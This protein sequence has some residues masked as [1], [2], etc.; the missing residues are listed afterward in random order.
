MVN[1]DA[2]SERCVLRY[3][4]GGLHSAGSP[5]RTAEQYQDGSCHD[6]KPAR[7][8]AL[9][10]ATHIDSGAPANAGVDRAAIA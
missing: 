8:A 3:A 5:L 9:F 4:C 10:E 1:G 7:M 6:G 2:F